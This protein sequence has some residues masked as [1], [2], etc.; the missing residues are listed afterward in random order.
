MNQDPYKLLAERLHATPNGYPPTESGVEI[1]ILENLFTPEQATLA[2][3]LRLTLETANQIAER[4]GQDRREVRQQLKTMQRKGLIAAGRTEGGRFGFG[5]SWFMSG[6]LM[7]LR[8]FPAWFQRLC[9]A[10]PFPSMINTVIETYLGVL[11]GPA[12]AR[13]LLVQVLWI[14]VL[15]GLCHL[16][17]RAGVRR[18]VIQ[19][20]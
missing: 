11:S 4:L 16:V 3:Q 20:G 6:F 2:A 17:L 18:L 1:R 10:T 12:L 13:A 9:N 5:L 15:L 8:F 7:P 14:A 19:G